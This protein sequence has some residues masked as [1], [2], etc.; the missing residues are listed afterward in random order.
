MQSSTNQAK[1]RCQNCLQYGHATYECK[2]QQTYQHRPSA[3]EKLFK[4]Q[5]ERQL[6]EVPPKFEYPTPAAYE[7]A[8]EEQ[9]KEE[10][11]KAK[12]ELH[13]SS[14]RDMTLRV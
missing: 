6:I 11:R 9:K 12:E 14:R 5:P 3:T 1:Q 13:C 8:L 10:K 2:N 7:R 4:K